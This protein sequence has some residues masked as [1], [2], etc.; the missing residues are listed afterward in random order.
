MHR[1]QKNLLRINGFQQK[2]TFLA[3]SYA[4]IKR[5]GEDQ[6]GW[7]SGGPAYLLR[8][9]VFISAFA[10]SHDRHAVDIQQ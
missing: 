1:L 9:P 10:Y 7:V 5:Y 4:V 2:H 3:F 6:A 8:L